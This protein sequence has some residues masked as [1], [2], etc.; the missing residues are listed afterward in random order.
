MNTPINF[1]RLRIPA[2]VAALVITAPVV[3]SAAEEPLPK[4]QR[5]KTVFKVEEGKWKG[6][7]LADGQPDVQGAWSNTI[8]NHSD[9]TQSGSYAER[10]RREGEAPARPVVRAPSRISDP[11]D[12]Q[13]PFQP[14]ARAKAEEFAKHLL[15][16]IKPEYIEPLARCAPA[17]PSKS[18][19]WHGFDIRQYKDYVVF[20]FDSGTRVIHLDNKP[21]LHQKVKLWNGDSRGHWEGNTLVVNVANNNGKGRFGRSGE[22]FSENAKITERYVFDSDQQKFLYHATYD[23][24]TVFT[25]PFTVTIPIRRVEKFAHDNWNNILFPAKHAGK[26]KILERYEQICT[27]NNGGHGNGGV[28]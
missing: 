24:P 12:G 23:D 7:R 1:R 6:P 25:R 4:F 21:H 9:L 3:V 15:D 28:R 20:L 22:F 19:M 16:P 14:W 13:V 18:F 26:E 2:L 17:G 11:A 10:N 5:E 8:G 27:E